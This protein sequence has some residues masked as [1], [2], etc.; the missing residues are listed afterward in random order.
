MTKPR[1]ILLPIDIARCPLEVFS[2]VNN[3]VDGN[4]AA[5]TLLHV[6][7]RMVP[8]GTSLEG[9]SP[10]AEKNLERL[11]LRFINPALSTRLCV[12][13]GEPA[14]EILAEI[15]QSD[16]DLVVLTS[17]R[18]SPVCNRPF[19]PGVVGKVVGAGL[20]AISVL[21]V[22]TRFNCEE[23]WEVVDEIVAALDYVGL[24][25]SAKPWLSAAT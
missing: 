21:H 18:N 8:E 17:H 4:G 13:I 23:Q 10:A 22:R 11:A 19:P 14:Q 6:L 16:V 20:C 3:F 12:R 5:V 25:T 1:K 2:Y 15:K 7:N 24:L 9:C